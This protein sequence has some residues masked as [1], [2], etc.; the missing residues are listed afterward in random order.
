MELGR[1]ASFGDKE[2]LTPACGIAQVRMEFREVGFTLSVGF[3][4]PVP[5]NSNFQRAGTCD[6]RS[7][8]AIWKR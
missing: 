6:T 4:S 5:Y 7:A 1:D 8:I 3:L 2:H